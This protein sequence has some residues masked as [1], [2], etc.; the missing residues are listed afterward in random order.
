MKPSKRLV[1]RP[2][3]LL[4]MPRSGTTW[5][6]QIFESS[7]D[8]I[9]RLSPNYSWEFKNRLDQNSSREEWASS[10]SYALH[11]DDEFITQNFR[12]VTGELSTF[13]PRSMETVKRLA[14][15]DTRFHDL[16][17]RCMELFSD[18]QAIYLVRHPGGMLNSWW[19]SKEFPAQARFADEWRGGA[20]RK[21]E[22]PGEYW[23][24]D[25]WRDLTMRFLALERQAPARYRVCRYEEL[26]RDRVR[27]ASDLFEFAGCALR[28]ETLAFLEESESRHDDRTYAVFKN[29][30]VAERWRSELPEDIREAI[31]AE[32]AGTP[33]EDYA[34]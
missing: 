5:L 34:S 1:T 7:P 24:F 4:G 10:F 9:V 32:L 28:P 20:C 15:K 12:R 33:L 29:P 19:R 18:A 26:V 30:S 6:S 8:F 22:G 21:I 13:P 14:I 25:D 2:L 23:G 27:I 16:Y 11:A 3:F 17:Q 31:R